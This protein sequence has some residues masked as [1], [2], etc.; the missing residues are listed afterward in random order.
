[1]SERNLRASTQTRF[2]Y[3]R[4]PQPQ[5]GLRDFVLSRM[6]FVQCCGAFPDQHIPTF[7]QPFQFEWSSLM[8]FTSQYRSIPCSESLVSL[9]STVSSFE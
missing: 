3:P 1:M 4:P 6:S 9:A 8:A 2:L 5:T 7:S